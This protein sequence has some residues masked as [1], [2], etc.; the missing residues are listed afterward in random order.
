MAFPNPSMAQQL[1]LPDLTVL[2]AW[3]S[4]NQI[5]YS[6]QNI[7]AASVGGAGAPMSFYNALFVDGMQ[8]AEDY[9]TTPLAP[10]QQLD[11]CFNYQFQ[12]TPP[13]HTI[14]VCADWRQNITESDEG[15]NCWQQ[16]WVMEEKLP[17]L[18][19]TDIRQEGNTIR[20]KIEN[21]GQGSVINPLGGTT[22]FCNALF[23]DGKEV[24]KD[25]VNIY[26]M[27]PGQFIDNPFD[28]YWEMT[29]PKHTIKACA[30]YEQNVNEAN[31]QN[32]C[33]ETTWYLEEKLP[34]LVIEEIKCDQENSQIGYIIKNVGEE[35]AKGGHSAT[36]SVDGKEVAHD[37]VGIDLKPGATYESW[38]KEYRWQCK[39]IKVQVC[40]DNYSE[41][42]ESNEQ[43]NCLESV[44][45]CVAD[46]TPPR[47][48][49]GPTISKVTQD[50]A[51]V[52]WETDEE[53]DS[54]LR[55][56]SSSGQYGNTVE[57][58]SLL[59][60]HCLSLLKLE[61]GTTYH[62]MI[63][64]KDAAG[65][66]LS[67]REL[68]FETLSPP[69]EK[70][71]SLSLHLPGKL[72]G[73]ATILADAGDNIG[74]DRVLFYLDGKPMHTDFSAPF[75]WEIDSG[76]FD[77]GKH[78]FGAQAF[79]AAGNMAEA[80]RDGTIRNHFPADLSPVRV[81][82]TH[83]ANR[84]EVYGEVDILAEI[85]HDFDLRISHIEF[86]VDERVIGGDDF[87]PPISLIPI[88]TPTFMVSCPWDT[89]EVRP[90]THNIMVRVR[91]EAENW[92]DAGILVEVVEPPTP[93]ISVH[94]DVQPSQNYFEVT[95]T[96][97]NDS[98][99]DVSNL[100]ISDT[101]SG[102]Q[103]IENAFLRSV[104]W[105]DFGPLR[106]TVTNDKAHSW[107]STLQASLGILQSGR[108]KVL[109]YYAVP[110]FVNYPP[111]G[112]SPMMGY[113]FTISFQARGREYSQQSHSIWSNPGNLS[114]AFHA[115]DYL[116]VTSPPELFS[117]YPEADVDELLST[118]AELA[119]EENGVLGYI[120]GGTTA[121]ELRHLIERD[122]EWS[123]QLC[124]GWAEDGYFLIVGETEIVP[125]FDLSFLGSIERDGS[126]ATL[127]VLLSDNPYA[128]SC[129][130]DGK[131]ELRVGRI[132]G[133]S[134][135]ELRIPIVT[136]L[137]VLRGA[138]T[139]GRN[140]AVVVTGGGD[141]QQDCETSGD[142]LKGILRDNQGIPQ[143]DIEMVYCGRYTGADNCERMNNIGHAVKAGVS[144]RDIIAWLGHGGP[145]GWVWAL[146]ASV[147]GV[148][149]EATDIYTEYDDS[150]LDFGTHAPVVLAASCFTGYYERASRA[151]PG[152]LGTDDSGENGIAEA[153]LRRGTAVYIGCNRSLGV[154]SATEF[155][156]QFFETYWT[157][158]RSLGDA[159][160]MLKDDLIDAD[161]T[162]P[163]NGG[164]E[165]WLRV[166]H[167][168]NLYGD[169]K[170]GR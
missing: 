98:D 106:A 33:M 15:N 117:H 165:E 84:S 22:S 32:N 60:E 113:E 149:P 101:D 133:N 74:V 7:G 70:K 9:V 86:I 77:E 85:S 91:D 62:L 21:V 169:P 3:Q 140:R 99:V 89:S 57:D 81:H 31:E 68:S 40:A 109:K 76:L 141:I 131:P 118:M 67:S 123:V 61:P 80:N 139:F 48:I 153:F 73:K 72:S 87:D 5:C 95:L 151:H 47:L 116:I 156:R 69:D 25:C 8:V 39:T 49:S 36:L 46:V 120:G 102:F 93:S 90:G 64:S 128:D 27:M 45:E 154:D 6:I 94:R 145:G 121:E 53:S 2:K 104:E 135:P 20:Y 51:R 124:P 17:D 13:Q 23:I 138:L 29:P 167:I 44:C 37:L 103:C 119:R 148:C 34:D 136:T 78:S 12:M 129:D 88:L 75:A 14:M 159:L 1:P 132:I 152:Y 30:D 54:L 10:G 58:R 146:D 137:D 161:I 55:Y 11:S 100:T 42:K 166:S 24:A 96:L 38:F 112:I 18:V 110:V 82:I 19:V 162:D 150:P 168:F 164:F 134:A 79:D 127:W 16:V 157:P 158:G 65:N 155:Q 83:P 43:N 142:R 63:E 28:F 71:P 147:S 122:G 35:T 144:D 143:D 125:S 108:T 163:H 160:V 41:V 52:C 170:Y 97:Q 26:E 50:S 59:K 105:G 92:G 107:R 66:K 115:A 56:D 114:S 111:G 126:R 130:D 4:G